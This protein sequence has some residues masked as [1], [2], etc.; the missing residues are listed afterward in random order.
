M[1]YFQKLDVASISFAEFEVKPEG[2][3]R[4]V[5]Y[6]ATLQTKASDAP[7]RYYMTTV[8]QQVKRGW[9]AIAHSEVPAKQSPE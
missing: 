5:S 8:W 1:Q 2:P 4:V 3:D 9:I 6:A 7:Q